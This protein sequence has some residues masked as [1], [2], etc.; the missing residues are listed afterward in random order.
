MLNL[1]LTPKA[2]NDIEGIY[3]YTFANWGIRQAE[4][5]QDELFEWMSRIMAT[6]EKLRSTNILFFTELKITNS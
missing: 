4:K 2:L 6:T 5:Y 3:E 1:K